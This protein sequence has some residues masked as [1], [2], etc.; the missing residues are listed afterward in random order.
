M[1]YPFSPNTF[2]PRAEGHNLKVPGN[3]CKKSMQRTLL[4]HVLRRGQG[5]PME[6]QSRSKADH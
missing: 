3:S 1:K 4:C 2:L 6:E 5:L